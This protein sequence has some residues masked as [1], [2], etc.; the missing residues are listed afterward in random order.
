LATLSQEA[1]EPLRSVYR[2]ERMRSSIRAMQREL[3]A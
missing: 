2:H 3:A 1:L